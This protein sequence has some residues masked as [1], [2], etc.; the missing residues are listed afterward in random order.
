MPRHELAVTS[1]TDSDNLKLEIADSD[2]QVICKTMQIPGMY[3]QCTVAAGAANRAVP[4]LLHRTVEVSS[5]TR[6]SYYPVLFS[7][8]FKDLSSDLSVA[9]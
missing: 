9:R 7:F 4:L 3:I 8:Q 2:W 6:H 1:H 5:S